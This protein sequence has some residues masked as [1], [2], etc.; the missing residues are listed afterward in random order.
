MAN[1]RFVPKADM[2]RCREERRY[3]ITSSA[4]QARVHQP[5]AAAPRIFADE[6]DVSGGDEYLVP[7][8]HWRSDASI[9]QCASG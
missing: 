7:L 2:L 5:C 9:Q 1:V 6:H 4:T 3:S 8:T